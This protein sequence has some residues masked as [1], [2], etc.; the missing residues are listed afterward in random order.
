MTVS[1]QDLR[2]LV[3]AE[4]HAGERI[5]RA[6][7]AAFPDL[8]RSRI[9]A[10]IE[11]GHVT[12]D[13][14]LVREPADSLRIGATLVLSV[15]PPVSSTPEPENISLPV[16]YEDADLIVIDKPAGLVVHPA[17]GNETGTLVN[18]LL[19]H[20]GDSLSGIGGE[21]RPG[22][23]HRLD[24]DTS[25]V[26]VV[27]KTEQAHVALS[28][29]FAARRIDRKYLALCWGVPSPGNG[30]Y[31]GAIGRDKA[32]RKRMAIVARGGKEALT[33]YK[34]LKSFNA[35]AALMECK[36]ATGRTHQIRVHFSANG[37]PL[38]GD[39]LYLRRIPA[40]AKR[41]PVETR[42]AALDFPRQAL[43]AARLGFVH[44]RTG[45]A[46]LFETM[47]PEDFRALELQLAES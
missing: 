34:V 21:R 23:V 35:C 7:A 19:A 28:N 42:D 17:P 13:G 24:K 44:P 40:V 37:H 5:D 16:L 31:E 18:A 11:A 41:L 22:I 6:L 46:L 33:H 32:D 29:D 38:I 43:H 3:A 9:K 39:P 8:S 30:D 14:A 1:S 20:C 10:L 26:M 15:P 25:G 12:R 45:E 4:Q 2:T 47:P 36:L 27:A